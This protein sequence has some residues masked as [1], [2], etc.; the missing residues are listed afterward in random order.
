MT[1]PL[2]PAREL[3]E[4]KYGRSLVES[5]RRQGP[6]PVYGTNGRCGSHDEALFAGP[7]V[8]LGRKGQGPLGVEWSNGDYWVI[9]TAYSLLPLRA[10]IDLRYSYFLIKFVGLNHLKDG[11]SNPSL[12]R[13]SF[14]SQAFP[15]PPLT[16]QRAIAEILGALEDRIALNRRMNETLEGLAQA[17]FKSWFVDFDPVRERITS[18]GSRRR[19]E[20]P[21]ALFPAAMTGSQLGEIPEGWHARPLGELVS[22]E[23]GLS[24]KGDGL[25]ES[26]LPMIN[27]GCF[28]GNG[29]FSESKLKFYAGDFKPKHLVRSGDIVVANTDVT[30]RREI[31]GSPAY[32]PGSSTSGEYLY[33]HHV[34][35]IRLADGAQDF[36]SFI[37]YSLLQR[38]FR[39]RAEGFA[40]GTTV[41]ALPREAILEHIVAVPP[42]ELVSSFASLI[43]PMIGMQR[44]NLAENSTLTE[45]R[46][47]LLPKLISGEIRIKDAEKVVEAAL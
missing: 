9:D 13:D 8:V 20:L 46:D 26:G 34:Y 22:L 3:F 41:L 32:V 19:A 7:G 10:D 1:W 11:T 42:R 35:A 28:L 14:G 16:D 17:I 21:A 23:K 5:K 18:Q 25:V 40:T 24:Y 47:V 33:T 12:A 2:V 38:S 31:L 4:L 30:Q 29:Q 37:Y 43:A 39:E 15:L 45:L 27:L 6:I 36:E 44:A